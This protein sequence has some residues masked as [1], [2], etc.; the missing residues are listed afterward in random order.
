MMP[1]LSGAPSGKRSDCRGFV[2]SFHEDGRPIAVGFG[3]GNLHL[4]QGGERCVFYNGQGA[5][6]LSEELADDQ[7]DYASTLELGGKVG[8]V[9]T[10]P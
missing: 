3:R 5:C 8:W 2:V 6:R 10:R 1:E 9:L 4:H 7:V